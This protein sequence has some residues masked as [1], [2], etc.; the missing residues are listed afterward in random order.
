MSEFI[1][2]RSDYAHTDSDK[3]RRGV[4]KKGDF[5]NYK[6]D[7]WSDT[8]GWAQS[9][10]PVKFV[11]VK[12]PGISFEE[13]ATAD[14]RRAWRDDF[15]YE[16]LGSNAAQ[17][18]YTVRV[19]EKNAGASNQNQITLNKV[20]A[21]LVKW[22]CNNIS[23]T[24]NSVQFDF[25][26]WQ[27]AQSEGFWDVDNISAKAAFVL[28]N[29]NATTGVADIT[30]TIVNESTKVAAVSQRVVQ[31]GGTVIETTATTVRFNLERS[32][33]LAKFRSDVKH[34]LEKVYKRHRYSISSAAVDAIIAAGGVVTYTKAQLL[35]AVIDHQVV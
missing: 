33:V 29:Y 23:A 12:C 31:Q 16:I 26:L 27:A 30:V 3:D 19:F 11:V 24:T 22:G 7:G 4:H 9:Q 34:A 35:A 8:P 25:R 13:A 15:D 21:W 14:Y 2:K 32:V 18:R 20:Q 5:V 10:Y 1:F 17:G 28:N 6:P